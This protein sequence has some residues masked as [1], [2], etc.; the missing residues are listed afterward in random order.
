MNREKILK[1]LEEEVKKCRKCG[2]YRSRTNPV[3]GMGN[4]YANIMFVGEAPGYY[5]DLRGLP[6]V[7]QAGKLLDRLLKE[8]GLTREDIY[9]GNVIK[10][11]PPGNRDPL[12]QEIEACKSYLFKQIE[13]IKPKLICTLGRFALQILVGKKVFI[14]R[15][16]GQLMEKG[17]TY[18]YPLFHPAAALHRV[19]LLKPLKEDFLRIPQ[20]LEKMEKK[21]SSPEQFL[22]FQP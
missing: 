5:E 19:P 22:L 7:G 14:T 9:I 21:V 15:Q 10:C 11:R 1:E 6:F 12:P 17:K 8:I 20:I 13:I 18:I 2:L 16:H 3:F 4:P